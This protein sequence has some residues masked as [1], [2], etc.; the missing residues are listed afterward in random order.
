MVATDPTTAEATATP[1][2]I[3]TLTVAER[4]GVAVTVVE[5][6]S[7]DVAG[8]GVLDSI[9]DVTVT[10]GGVVGVDVLGG[11]VTVCHTR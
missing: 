4:N 6:C 5:P 3:P 11:T 8:A 9:G 10:V 1:T 7:E 2:T